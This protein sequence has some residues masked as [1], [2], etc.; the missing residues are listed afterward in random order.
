MSLYPTFFSFFFQRESLCVYKVS[1][2]KNPL[3]SSSHTRTTR[4]GLRFD[5]QRESQARGDSQIMSLPFYTEIC[6]ICVLLMCIP[7]SMN[8]G[9]R[10]ENRSPP[11]IQIHWTR[12]DGIRRR[13][14]VSK[15]APTTATTQFAK[16]SLLEGVSFYVKPEDLGP[17]KRGPGEQI[18]SKVQTRRNSPLFGQDSRARARSGLIVAVGTHTTSP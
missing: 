13:C 10:P 14:K 12:T 3:K 9:P 7:K 2:E 4:A 1:C 5:V 18:A 8:S 11:Q 15:V 16:A 6:R 17:S